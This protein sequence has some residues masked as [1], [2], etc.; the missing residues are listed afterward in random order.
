MEFQYR[1]S[2]GRVLAFG[3][4]G[5]SFSPGITSQEYFYNLGAGYDNKN[6]SVYTNLS[7]IGT[8]YIAD[9]GFIQGQEYYDASRDTT[10]RIGYNHWYSRF[11]YTF[12]PENPKINS[13]EVNARYILD[14]DTAFNQLNSDA[15][16]GYTLNHNNTSIFQ[17]SY[18]YNIIN[19]LFPFTFIGEE[20]LPAGIYENSM[21]EVTFD[22]DQRRK[23]IFNA[24]VL[25]GRFY[26]GGRCKFS[27]HFIIIG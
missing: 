26:G 6:I 16:I 21:G 8:N 13:H 9:M 25:F 15:E 5:K 12:Y 7:G 1:S 4:G 11:G 27:V 20:P 2:D 22:S 3:G 19:L 24:G 10:I 18:N 23:F 17:L 14:V